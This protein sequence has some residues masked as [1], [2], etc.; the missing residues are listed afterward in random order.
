MAD[1]YSHEELVEKIKSPGWKLVG[2]KKDAPVTGTL[3][4]LLQLTHAQN[5]KG[6]RPGLIRQIETEVELDMLQVAQLWRYL[7][8]PT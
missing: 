8:L 6:E 4:H 1:K 3:E 2:D 7:G 5:A